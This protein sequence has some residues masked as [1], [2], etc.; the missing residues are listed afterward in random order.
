MKPATPVTSQVLGADARC[1]RRLRYGAKITGSQW[2][3][4]RR[5]ES[6]QS[7]AGALP[8]DH[9]RRTLRLFSATRQSIFHSPRALSHNAYKSH[10]RRLLASPPFACAETM[11]GPLSRFCPIPVVIGLQR[12]T[13]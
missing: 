8:A 13:W 7:C 3:G 5:A 2:K 10:H 4:T 12:A 6:G 11:F 1:S 9:T